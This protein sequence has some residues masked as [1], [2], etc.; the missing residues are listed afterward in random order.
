MGW[1]MKKMQ[2]MHFSDNSLL[3]TI[4]FV[5]NPVYPFLGATPDARICINGTTGI[6]E[7]KCLYSA[8]D[9]TIAETSQ[10]VKSFCLE[11]NDNNYKLKS[12]HD[13]WYQI[14]VNYSLQVH[15]SVYSL[16]TQRLT[17]GTAKYC[18]IKT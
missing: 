8:R 12:N 10:L 9:M 11:A 7:I 6:A 5:V 18:R 3:H 17:S 14:Q 4:G 16:F 13:Y 2:S 15:H 1:R